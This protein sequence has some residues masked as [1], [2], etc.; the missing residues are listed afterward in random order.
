[1]PAV[2]RVVPI[3]VTV[4]AQRNRFVAVPW[5][6]YDQKRYPAWVPPLRMSV[7]DLLD[8]KNNPFYQYAKIQLFIAERD[9]RDVGRIAAIENRGH[10]DFHK[11]KIGF[12]GF[13]ESI[14]D[15]DVAN[16]LFAHAADWLREQGFTTMRGPM[17]PSMNHD[18]GVLVDG[19]DEHPTIMTTWNPP[20]TPVLHENAGFAKANDLLTYLLTLEQ[21]KAVPSRRFDVAEKMIEKRG[22]TCRNI[23]FNDL[24][25]DIPVCCDLYNHAFEGLWGFFPMT[26]A[27][28]THAAH[29]M[30]AILDP[31][32]CF[33]MEDGDE[34]IG[35]SLNMPDINIVLKNIPNGKLLPTGIFKLLLG[36][37]KMRQ[38][39]RTTLIGVK[40]SY[41]KKGVF[42]F[43]NHEYIKRVIKYN[44]AFTDMAWMREDNKLLT[45]S[46]E[47]LG[48]T[49]NRR[50]RVYDR[51]L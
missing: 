14:N 12:Y 1:V 24:K 43:L 2:C 26:H 36:K 21:I 23:D 27:D 3:D 42:A 51:P 33:L 50:W 28:L 48:G 45:M 22:Y 13:F 46:V 34:A 9:G 47:Y 10:N 15:Q 5:E 16:A 29:D 7:H 18:A 11:D 25:R 38:T 41:R 32:F 44:V 31:N 19:F 30:K 40:P 49:I 35:F 20:Y 4:K 6:I 37:K 39:M 8:T 17:H